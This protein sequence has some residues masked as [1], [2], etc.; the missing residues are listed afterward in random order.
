M[1]GSRS[2]APLKVSVS[3]VR[4]IVGQSMTPDLVLRYA[5]AFGARRAPGPIVVARDTRPSGVLFS[6]LIHGGLQ[7]VG[8]RVIAIGITPT[9]TAL[10]EVLRHRARGGMIVTASHNPAPWN[11]LKFVGPAGSF[12]TAPKM[13]QLAE[14]ADRWTTDALVPWGRRGSLVHDPRAVAHHVARILKAVDAAAIRRRRFTVALDSCNGA[15][16]VAAPQLLQALGCRVI[17]IHVTPSGT[18]PRGPEPTPKNL[19]ALRRAVRRGRAAVGFAQ[20]PDADRLSLVDEHGRPLSEELTLAVA[21]QH[22]LRQRRGP[23]VVNLSTSR[24]IDEVAAA[25]G[26][27]VWRTP[28]GEVHVI[29]RMR[30]VRA[31][32]GGEGNGGVID[33]RVTWGRDSLAGMALVLEALARG[34]QP[35]SAI[36]APLARWAMVK[37][38]IKMSPAVMARLLR[39][40]PARFRGGRVTGGDGIRVDVPDGWVHVRPSNTEPIVRV[41][42]EAATRARAE[43]MCRQALA[44]RS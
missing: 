15:G 10:G 36:A 17:G 41:F 33:P 42:A 9:P 31:V 23:V 27:P 29:Q 32:I 20:D 11:G 34:G 14:A 21:V 19:A 38:K 18:F 24:I 26:V 4:G 30:R 1:T 12:L 37:R 44:G 6:D 28:V 16:A 43:A 2:R 8:C 7:A 39:G 5:L 13:R 3:G 25:A 40:L 22:R 35:L